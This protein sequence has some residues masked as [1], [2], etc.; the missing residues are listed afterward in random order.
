M[1]TILTTLFAVSAILSVNAAGNF[2][3]ILPTGSS[4][5]VNK[6]IAVRIVKK[7]ITIM[8]NAATNDVKIIYTAD[9]AAKGIIIVLD[10]SGKKLLQQD[11]AIIAGKNNIN[12]N[13]FHKLNE[14]TY[15]I[16]LISDNETYTSSFMIWK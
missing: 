8:P 6:T 15:S 13:D 7:R 10:E 14:G 16:Q 3:T 11:A 5:T 2:N 4:L 1:K 9:K 12:I